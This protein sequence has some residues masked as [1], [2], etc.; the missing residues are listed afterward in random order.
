MQA[1]GYEDVVK[2]LPAIDQALRGAACSGLTAWQ[3]HIA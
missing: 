3:A 2:N 1:Q